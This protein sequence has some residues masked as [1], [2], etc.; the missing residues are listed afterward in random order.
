MRKLCFVFA[1]A[2]VICLSTGTL[3]AEGN[4][5]HERFS[6]TTTRVDDTL[7]AFPVVVT[8]SSN[9]TFLIEFDD[10]G[11]PDRVHET[12]NQAVIEYSAN[13][14]TLTAKGSGGID[15]DW[16]FNPD[17]TIMATTFGIDLLLVIPGYGPVFLDAG[18]G[19]FFLDKTGFHVLFEAGPASYDMA[20]FC[21]ALA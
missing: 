21:G 7:C 18:R 12:V 10:Q 6:E 9:L 14:K 3:F 17:R 11:R 15:Y 16:E 1:F 2:V 4:V 8:S 13:G 20:A 19:V 5:F